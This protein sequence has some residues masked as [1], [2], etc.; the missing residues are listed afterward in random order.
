MGPVEPQPSARRR[1][2]GWLVVPLAL[3]GSGL[4]VW[5]AST[6]AVTAQ[7]RTAPNAWAA[8]Q[9]ALGAD[10]SGEA[11]FTADGLVPGDGQVRCVAV[12]Y[13]GDLAADVRMYVADAGGAL[14]PHLDVTVEDGTG[15]DVRCTGFV[16]ARRL[17]GAGAT[18]ASLGTAHATWADGLAGWQPSGP[19][20]RTY[21]ITWTFRGGDG[22]Q[23]LAAGGRFVWEARSR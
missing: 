15:G 21:R 8:G 18:L 1:R 6:A 23:G 16:P 22:T 5:Q 10:G 7:T 19:G 13:D 9:V 14:G 4:V 3:A 2:L 12:R 20:T 11:Y 17:T